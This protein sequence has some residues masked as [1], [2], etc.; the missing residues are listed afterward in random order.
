MPI[1]DPT[2]LGSNDSD[3]P[4]AKGSRRSRR[5]RRLGSP[6]DWPYY[7]Y[8]VIRS[9]DTVLDGLHKYIT[10]LGTTLKIVGQGVS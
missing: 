2:R 10:R 5:L 7:Y 4:V 9:P 6:H 1:D 3:F 8:F